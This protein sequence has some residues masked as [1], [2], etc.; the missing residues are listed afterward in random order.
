MS[1]LGPVTQLRGQ[2]VRPHDLEVLSDPA[3]DAVEAVVERVVRLGFEVRVD[4]VAG[5]EPIWAQLTRDGARR[6]SLQPGDTVYVRAIP[7][8]EESVA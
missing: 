8:A 3:P 4:A 5:G 7:P 2:L 6:L 1:F